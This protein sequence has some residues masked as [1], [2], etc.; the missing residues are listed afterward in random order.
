[1]SFAQFEVSTGASEEVVDI[2]EK[3]SEM[4]DESGVKEGICLVYAPHATAAVII[5]ELEPNIERDYVKF[6]A[7]FVPKGDYAHNQIDDNAEAHLKSAF[8]GSGKCV[9]IKD[10]KLALGTW[11]SIMLC[12][13]D[14]PRKRRVI[15]VVK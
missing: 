12:E 9:P 15:V 14:G 3:V 5:N 10:G 7:R 13:F 1:M 4:A 11:Q 2:T 8:F 6:F